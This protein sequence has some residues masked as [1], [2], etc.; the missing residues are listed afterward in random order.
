MGC[1]IVVEITGREALLLWTIPF[2]TGNHPS[3]DRLA[4]MLVN[5]TGTNSLKTRTIFPSGSILDDDSSRYPL[6]PSAFKLNR[7]VEPI[8]I[9]PSQWE[10]LA[11]QFDA[12]ENDLDDKEQSDLEERQEWIKLSTELLMKYRA[13][14]WLDEFQAWFE[15]HLSRTYWIGNVPVI[16]LTPF[17]SPE[18]EA[19]FKADNERLH[20]AGKTS[21]KIPTNQRRDAQCQQ[22]LDSLTEDEKNKF[23]A[24]QKKAIRQA[25]SNFA[26]NNKLENLWHAG[27][28]G[29]W[30]KQT[31]IPKQESG[32][33]K[34]V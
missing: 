2:V 22:Y 23:L 30:K 5:P 34:R 28:D 32:T 14:L 20:K 8:L 18:H 10:E 21:Q 4:Q 3:P 17:M 1:K 16:C 19:F 33:R 29:W 25:L 6:F 12:L 26:S 13:Y 7:E 9:P 15:Q 24:E 31:L 27:F 11:T